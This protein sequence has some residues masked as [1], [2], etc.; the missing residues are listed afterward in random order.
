ML[1]A[2]WP[3]ILDQTI[4]DVAQFHN[5]THLLASFT[6]PHEKGTLSSPKDIENLS[7]FRYIHS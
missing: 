6:S 7:K 5:Q 3:K 4:L 1:P 2:W